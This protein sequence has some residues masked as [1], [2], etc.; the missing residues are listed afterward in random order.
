MRIQLYCLG[1]DHMQLYSC[2]NDTD[3]HIVLV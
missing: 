3:L 2:K 1:A